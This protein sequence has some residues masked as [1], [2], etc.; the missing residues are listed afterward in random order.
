LS[1]VAAALTLALVLFASAARARAAGSTTCGA[2]GWPWIALVDA[3]WPPPFDGDFRARVLG[4]LA[5]GLEARHLELC[6]TSNT[7]GAASALAISVIGPDTLSVTVRDSVTGKRLEREIALAA[8]PGDA[9]PLTVA[10]VA[11]ELLRASWIELALPDAPVAAHSVAPQIAALALVPIAPAPHSWEL[12]A[13][14]AAERFGGGTR[15]AGVDLVVR[16]APAR[17]LWLHAAIALRRAADVHAADGLVRATVLGADV[18]AEVALPPADRRWH[19]AVAASGRL[20]RASLSGEPRPDARG[21]QATATAF[22]L[23]AGVR[24]ALRLTQSFGLSLEAAFG[25]PV[26]GVDLLDGATRV[27]GLSG[28]MGSLAFGATWRIP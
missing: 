28:P 2:R 15:Q 19:L 17:P 4:Q 27:A 5:A 22:Y 26:R 13:A 3:P 10:L 12:G 1:R 7:A 23:C 14:L 9:R 8:V 25:V 11:D 16:A 24:G 20:L 21:G 6:A 18:G